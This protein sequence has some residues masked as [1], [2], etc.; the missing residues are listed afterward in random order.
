MPERLSGAKHFMLDT[1][2][3][4]ALHL[5]EPGA[6]T[7]EKLLRQSGREHQVWLCFISL[8]EFFY[9]IEQQ[10]GV[11]EARKSYA[12]LK[13]LPLIII[14]SDEELGLIAASLKANYQ[15][16]LA[17]SWIAAAAKKLDAVLVHKDPEFEQLSSLITLRNL[18]YKTV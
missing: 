7:I 1:S 5:D 9:I 3:L 2:A 11:E 16:S 14:E 8:M 13:Q 15:L 18:P 17:D 6:A 4:L 10:A 12:A